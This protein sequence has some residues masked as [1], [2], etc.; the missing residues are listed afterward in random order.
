MKKYEITNKFIEFEGKTLYRIKA[1]HD[2]NDV[3][4][5]DLGGFVES[6]DNLSHHGDCWIYGNT[7]VLD[8]AYVDGNARVLGNAVVRHSSRITENAVICKNAYISNSYIHGVAVITD[9]ARIVCESTICGT[10]MICGNTYI[11][12]GNIKSNDEYLC[13]ST[14][15]ERGEY[16]NTVAF[17]DA[18]NTVWIS[19][20]Y[21]EYGYELYTFDE[22]AR[23]HTTRRDIAVVNAVKSY[24]E[25]FDS[26]EI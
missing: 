4:T 21:E 5:G 9:D 7:K 26:S 14:P 1:L 12:A 18:D 13:I 6:E 24:F 22:H 3:K 19:T 17:R 10:T 8:D 25:A 15:T 11:N 2:F 23:Y 20:N 16:I